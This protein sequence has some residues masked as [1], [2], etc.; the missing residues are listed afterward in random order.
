VTCFDFLEHLGLAEVNTSLLFFQKV[1]KKFSVIEILVRDWYSVISSFWRSIQY[2]FIVVRSFGQVILVGLL[3]LFNIVQN[4]FDPSSSTLWLRCLSVSITSFSR[5][6]SVSKIGLESYNVKSMRLTYVAVA[7][8]WTCKY[9]IF[10][11]LVLIKTP[12]PYF[13]WGKDRSD[14]LTSYVSYLFKCWGRWNFLSLLSRILSFGTAFLDS[15]SVHPTKVSINSFEKFFHWESFYL[16]SSKAT[17]P[18]FI[19]RV[20]TPRSFV[21]W[22]NFWT[23]CERPIVTH[24]CSLIFIWVV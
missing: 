11:L 8:I 24:R 3:V 21:R 7:Y 16:S 9:H 13:S 1:L 20:L 4:V 10:L 6:N 22:V 23:L 19:T 18:E 2:D 14:L 12:V 5:I 17:V 15:L